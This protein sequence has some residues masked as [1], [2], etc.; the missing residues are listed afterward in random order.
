[1][2]HAENHFRRVGILCGHDEMHWF[3]AAIP[4]GG[5]V[6]TVAEAKEALKPA[7]V[8][9]KERPKSGKRRPK[10]DVYIRQGEWYFL[11]WSH[12]S[13]NA[14]DVLSNAPLIRGPGSTPHVCEFMY[15]DGKREYAC[16]RFPKLAFFEAEYRQILAT[17]RKAEQWKWRQLPFT[18]VVYVRGSISHPDH[19]TLHLDTW[20]RAVLNT[21]AE[22]MTLAR[23]VYRD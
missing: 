7:L 10:G 20:H 16:P 22:A 12:A 5:E 4:E 15:L 1:M 14:S 8:K 2:L 11:P 3:V 21:E 13:V 18:P 17:R 23:M 19:S 6:R 9:R